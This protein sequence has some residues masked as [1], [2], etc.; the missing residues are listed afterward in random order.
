MDIFSVGK[1]THYFSFCLYFSV[2]YCKF[3]FK[4]EII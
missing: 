1:I 2:F 4:N 3:A